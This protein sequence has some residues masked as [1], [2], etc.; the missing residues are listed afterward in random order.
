MSLGARTQHLSERSLAVYYACCCND[1]S[2]HWKQFL[3]ESNGSNFSV[4][5]ATQEIHED[6]SLFESGTAHHARL[7]ALRIKE[8]RLVWRH[9]QFV[10]GQSQ[11]L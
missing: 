6:F 5:D 9:S 1:E 4:V 11:E 7:A 2:V 10:V 8:L 3:Q